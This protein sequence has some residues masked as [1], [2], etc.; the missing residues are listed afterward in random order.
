MASYKIYSKFCLPCVAGNELKAVQKWAVENFGTPIEVVRTT[1]R[2]ALQEEANEIWGG[3]HYIA[4]IASFDDD[5]NVV[6]KQDFWDFVD[7][8]KG[9]AMEQSKGAGFMAEAKKKPAKS[10]KKKAK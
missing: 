2:P 1:Y 10:A 9:N 4:F 5:G 3:V 6:N 8:I 7:L